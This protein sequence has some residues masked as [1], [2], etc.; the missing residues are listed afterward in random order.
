MAGADILMGGHGN[1]TYVINRIIDG[2]GVTDAI[3]ETGTVTSTADLV[4]FT[5]ANAANQSY[6]LTNLV[7][8]L[9]IL[10]TF[11]GNG[12]GNTLA[13]VITGNGAINILNGAA[14]MDTLNGGLGNDRLTGGADADTFILN[15]APSATNIDLITDLNEVGNDTIRLE[16]T[17]AGLFT[18]IL[19]L[20]TLAANAYEEN[21]SGAASTE[22]S[23]IIYEIDT[24]KLWYDFNGN[25]A[26][27]GVHFAT[28][29]ANQAALYSNADFFII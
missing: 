3:N 27:G 24:G 4:Q 6:T 22:T 10:G 12:T 28:L 16:N 13:N 20:G 5:A 25:A 14:G 29:D 7:E 19:T 17:G 21:A 15:T 23:R 26:G 1:D 11:A 18:G 2:A 9:T 8:N